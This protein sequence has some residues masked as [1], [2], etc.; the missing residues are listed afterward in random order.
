MYEKSG[1]DCVDY[2]QDHMWRCFVYDVNDGANSHPAILQ[3]TSLA[4]SFTKRLATSL[5]FIYPYVHT[6]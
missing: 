2:T 3:I 5:D 6:E 1:G 4:S